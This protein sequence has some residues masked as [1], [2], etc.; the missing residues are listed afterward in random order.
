VVNSGQRRIELNQP[1]GDPICNNTP[2]AG[3]PVAIQIEGTL[4]QQFS[5]QTAAKPKFRSAPPSSSQPPTFREKIRLSRAT[6]INTRMTTQREMEIAYAAQQEVIDALH[7][8][9][10]PDLAARLE[11]CMIARQVRH[12]GDGWPYSCRSAACVWCRRPMILGWWAGMREWSQAATTLSLAIIPSLSPAGLCNAARRLRRG[13]RDVRDRTARRWRQWRTVAFAGMMG[14]DDMI[15]VA[16]QG[17]D[18]RAVLDVLR[19]RWPSVVLKDLAQEEPVWA[20]AA[21][22]AVDLGWHRRGVEPL[23]IAV[24]SQKVQCK[25]VAPTPM[26][27]PMPVLV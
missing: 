24:M 11:R 19:R 17:A 10:N 16:H 15:M 9:G 5:Q 4:A 20:M 7:K 21:Y 6:H 8:I 13:L 27:E 25:V 1:C 18:R 23:R 14:G 26:I 12:Y 3:R 22:D 2:V